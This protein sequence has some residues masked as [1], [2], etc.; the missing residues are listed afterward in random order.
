M[1]PCLTLTP[2]ITGQIQLFL[3]TTELGLFSLLPSDFYENDIQL[4]YACTLG[5]S[6][7]RAINT[8]SV[9][10]TQGK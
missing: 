9:C 5:Y 3:E 2:P 10:K 8:F 6:A 1:L 7:T 4:P